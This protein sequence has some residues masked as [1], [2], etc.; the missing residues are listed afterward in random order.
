MFVSQGPTQDP[1]SLVPMA[2][3]IIVGV[4]IFWRTVIKVVAICLILLVVL[5]FSQLL[6]SAH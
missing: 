1:G 2:L 4:V 6:Q 5:G 3:V